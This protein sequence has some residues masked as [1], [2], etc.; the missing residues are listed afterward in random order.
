MAYAKGAGAAFQ[1]LI[2]KIACTT[3][4]DRDNWRILSSVSD[5]LT[6]RRFTTDDI[7]IDDNNRNFE[8]LEVLEGCRHRISDENLRDESRFY[9][10]G[11]TDIARIRL[12]EP[13][14]NGN[15]FRRHFR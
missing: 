15:N 4:N 6:C 8:A 9:F 12:L 3:I 11:A 10:E 5:P 1:H 14:Q 7:D 13:N 2:T